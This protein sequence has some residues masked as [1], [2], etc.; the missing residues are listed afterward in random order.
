MLLQIP[1]KI[2][3]YFCNFPYSIFLKTK[4][5]KSRKIN[6]GCTVIYVYILPRIFPAKDTLIHSLDSLNRKTDSIGSQI[7]NIDPQGYN[8]TTKITFKNYF[9]LLGSDL[10][11]EFTK[12]FR[13]TRKNWGNLEN[14]QQ[15]QLHLSFADE[16]IQKFTMKVTRIALD[17][18][19]LVTSLQFW[20]GL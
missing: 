16:T 1:T 18:K 3:V 7:N 2:L 19:K 20:R 4:H 15:W 14:L 10:K 17:F 8:E 5:E 9:I 6:S 11:Q 12:P 13:M